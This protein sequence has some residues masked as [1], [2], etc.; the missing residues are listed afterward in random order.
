[1]SRSASIEYHSASTST[2]GFWG[3]S[4]G[5]VTHPVDDSR[6][7]RLSTDP[8]KVWRKKYLARR[9]PL[10]PIFGCEERVHISYDTSRRFVLAFKTPA[11]FLHEG[12]LA[13]AACPRSARRLAGSGNRREPNDDVARFRHYIV[14]A[15]R[16]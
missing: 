15:L 11:A 7:S 10:N 12:V 14:S 13:G 8:P 5:F 6:T 16:M 1:M 2:F 4:T 3:A 9:R